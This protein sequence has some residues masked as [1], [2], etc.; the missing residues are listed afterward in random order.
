M[1]PEVSSLLQTV[2]ARYSRFT[3]WQMPVPGGTARKF[4]SA[5]LPQRRNS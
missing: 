4:F 1:A 3:W 5:P 2:L